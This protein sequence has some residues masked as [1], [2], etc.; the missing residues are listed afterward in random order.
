MAL[1]R[2]WSHT[3]LVVSNR[4][5]CLCAFMMAGCQFEGLPLAA[6]DPAQILVSDDPLPTSIKSDDDVDIVWDLDGS[7]NE[8]VDVQYSADGSSWSTM[9]QVAASAET[10][11]FLAASFPGADGSY[12]FR[13]RTDTQEVE[14]GAVIVDRT[15]PTVGADQAEGSCTQTI[16]F[17]LNAG[18][19]A[20]SAVTYTMITP[21]A[22]GVLSGCLDG[23][24]TTACSYSA[25]GAVG[26][27]SIQYRAV[28]AAG[29]QSGLATV[30]LS[31]G[32][33]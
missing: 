7:S 21:P 17:T 31:W 26:S 2:S 10:F 8:T 28:D 14:L 29:N 22:S 20:L 19:D 4:A 13:L 16:T 27:A 15:P 33:N 23:T 1:L 12:E 6:S 9:G 24:S 32:C 11:N 3:F 5:V 25:V 18:T 30:N